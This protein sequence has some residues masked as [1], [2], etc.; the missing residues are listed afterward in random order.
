M[1]L[2]RPELLLSALQFKRCARKAKRIFAILLGDFIQDTT[3]VPALPTKEDP[4]KDLAPDI[5]AVLDKYAD[6][7]EEIP[8]GLPPDRG[9]KHT[10]PLIPGAK[11]PYKRMYRLSPR[12]REEV[13][14]QVKELLAKG[15]IEPSQ[16]PFGAPIVFAPKKDGT[17]RMCVDY[18][19]LNLLTVKNRY[20]LPRIDDLLDRLHGATVFTS[21]DLQ[22]GFNQILITQED[23][24]KTAFLTHRG[25]Y[26]YRVLCFGI[27]NAPS[28]FQSVM[29]RVLAKVIGTT[30]M[31]Y[32]D[33][34]LVYSK[35]REDHA[36]HLEEV[37]QLLREAKLY[38]KLSKCTFDQPETRFLGHVISAKGIAVD[39]KKIEV[40]TNWPTPK[41]V[42]HVRSFLGLATLFRRF[43]KHFST[44]AHNLHALLHKDRP[45]DWGPKEDETFKALK[46]SLSTAPILVP[47]NMEPDAP[48]FHITCDASQV[49]LGALLSRTDTLS[50]TR[51]EKCCLLKRGTAQENM[52]S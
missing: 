2:D 37:L 8:A 31:V 19:A 1:V 33:D 9:V 21:M 42:G 43:C 22:T 5:R 12:E 36:A 40:I 18:R 27:S 3:P 45:W 25:L 28:T 4:H 41:N 13:E 16:S 51:A 34:I 10:I 30:C 38:A 39:P 47:P 20:P 11:A 17:I 7:F 14:K 46:L 44:I 32:M 26:Q 52:N 23:V 15:W 50:R 35:R 49:G 6:V 29:N 48:P 24:E